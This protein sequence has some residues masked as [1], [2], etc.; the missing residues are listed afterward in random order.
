MRKCEASPIGNLIRE[1]LRNEG[2]ETPLNQY[3]LIHS[4]EEV[5]GMGIA[6][7]TG[8]MYIRNQ[9]L[10]I[11]IT[12]PALRNELSMNRKSITQRLNAKIEA[13]VITDIHFY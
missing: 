9:T 4:W 5:M 3:R 10:Y 13:N 12:S 2:L 6:R 8:N 11:Q 1:A 7:Y